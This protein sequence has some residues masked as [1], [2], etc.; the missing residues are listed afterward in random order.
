MRFAHCEL[1]RFEAVRRL[2]S[3]LFD[4][5]CGRSVA[6]AVLVCKW[7]SRIIERFEI[8]VSQ[9][10]GVVGAYPTTVFVVSDIRKRK[11]KARVTGE[12]PTLVTVNVTFVNLTRTK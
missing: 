2:H 11:T 6:V 7:T 5:F 8:H 10:R 9:V 4:V 3:Y 1:A 12:V